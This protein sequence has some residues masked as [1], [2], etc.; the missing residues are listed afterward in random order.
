[1]TCAVYI[2]L[3]GTLTENAVNYPQIY[4]NAVE[5]AGITGL[6][7]TYEDYTDRFFKYFQNGWAFPR[8]QAMLDLLD[9]HNIDDL[10][11]TD[12]FGEAWDELETEQTTFRTGAVQA[13]QSL[14]ENHAVGVI[15][16]G[17][18]RLQRM[19]LEKEHLSQHLQAIIIST[20]IGKNKP[21]ADFF[22]EAQNAIEADTYV[23]ISHDLRRDILPAKRLDMK[24][25]WLGEKDT[26][27]NQQIQQ[28]VDSQIDNLEELPETVN[29]LCQA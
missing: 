19:K 22:K 13:I 21:N 3:D 14:A 20:E 2:N 27:N 24:T 23:V 8:R 5:Q 28:L 16:S 18:S 26:E 12:A 15:T 29:R 4:Y 17:T 10:G 9:E 7:D 1:M 25:V 11:L 6:D